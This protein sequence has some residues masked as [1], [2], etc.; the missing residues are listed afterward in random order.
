MRTGHLPDWS[1]PDDPAMVLAAVGRLNPSEYKITHRFTKKS[2]TYDNTY[3][4]KNKPLFRRKEVAQMQWVDSATHDQRLTALPNPIA[5]IWD[6]NHP[7]QGPP[8]WD[9]VQYWPWED[10]RLLLTFIPSRMKSGPDR[11]VVLMYKPFPLSPPMANPLG[12]RPR[13]MQYLMSYCCGGAQPTSCPVGERLVGCCSHCTTVLCLSMVL[14]ANPGVITTTHKG[15]RLLD[16]KNPQQM[17]EE[18]LAEVS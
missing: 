5:Y 2:F 1:S 3:Q 4:H 16:R 7:P 6:E 9:P 18:T 8:G 14:P 11:A 15:V 17:D 13:N 12:F 10:I